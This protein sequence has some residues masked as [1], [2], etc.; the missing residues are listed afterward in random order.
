MSDTPFVHTVFHPSDFSAASHTAFTHALALVLYRQ[1]SLTVMHCVARDEAIDVWIDSPQVRETLERWGLLEPG[2]P[3]S[4]VHE[5]LA[6]RVSKVNIRGTDPLEA[7]LSGLDKRPADLI[8]LASEGRQGLPRWLKRSVAEGVSRRSRTMTLFVP[9][10]VQ[11]FVSSDDG[12]ISL[13]RILV[14]VD[15]EPR[16]D[17][18]VTYAAR[19]G[20]MSFESPVEITLLRG[21][22]QADWPELNEP[23]LQSCQWNRVHRQGDVVE[24]IVSTAQELSSDLIVMATAGANGIL[25]AL[26]GSVTEQVLRQAPCPV[27]AVPAR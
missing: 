24:Q 17:D 26:R 7:I 4:A 2:S 22:P 19:A 1:G 20:V 3:R 23:D 14:P 10:G 13:Q 16:P 11:G 6:L 8:V 15:H 21:G 9:G 18:A 12:R 5:K 25:D 27:L